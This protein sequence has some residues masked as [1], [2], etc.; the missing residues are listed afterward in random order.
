VAIFGVPAALQGLPEELERLGA[1]VALCE[2]EHD[3]AMLPPAPSL[4]RQMLDYAYP[5]GI[6]ARLA[7]FLPLLAQRRIDGVVIYAQ[8]FCHHNL[9]LARVERELR[10]WPTLVVEGDVPGPLPGRDRSRLEAFVGLLSARAVRPCALLRT[11]SPGPLGGGAS[12]SMLAAT[13]DDGCRKQ[14]AKCKTQDGQAPWLSATIRLRTT[15]RRDF[16]DHPPSHEASAGLRRPSAS[17]GRFGG[18]SSPITHD[19]RSAR[20]CL[21]TSADP[22][23]PAPNA[24]H[25]GLDLGSRFAK[26]AAS[27]G[28]DLRKLA[29]DS[30][31]F[32][33]RFASRREG[34]LVVELDLLL[35]ALG[36]AAGPAGPPVSVVATGYGRNLLAFE[37]ARTIPEIQAHAL[38]AASQ[39]AGGNFLLLDL[40]GQDSKAILVA[41]GQVEAFVMNDKCA[42]GSGRYVENMARLLGLATEEVMRH[43]EDPVALTNVCATFGESEIVGAV[44]DGIPAGRIAAGIMAS[45]AT[46]TAQLA[47]KLPRSHGLAT[48]LAGGL[49]ESAALQ[50]FL[51]GLLEPASLA[52]LPDPRFNGALGCLASLT[53]PPGS[54]RPT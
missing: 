34:R 42:A 14:D 3:F 29:M 20:S 50:H 6:E 9:E 35:E 32:Y 36:L 27:Q 7:R 43:W 28:G 40:G 19:C 2:T 47:E 46:R 25:L 16:G 21:A 52:A 54:A 33:R 53:S 49:A 37:N 10:D 17:A 26:V 41:G 30:M 45:V 24:L 11:A 12:L 31:E 18:T 1:F 44:V 13:G 8:A 23:R 15:L 38:G 51:N 48:W 39:I 4:V 22:P 5:Y